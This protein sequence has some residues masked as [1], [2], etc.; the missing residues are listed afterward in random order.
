MSHQ[1]VISRVWCLMIH[2]VGKKTTLFYFKE[3]EWNSRV[4]YVVVMYLH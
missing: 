3:L 1:A 2:E 4:I